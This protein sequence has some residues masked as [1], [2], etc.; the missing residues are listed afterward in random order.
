MF[1][2]RGDHKSGEGDQRPEPE[3][4]PERVNWDA[5]TLMIGVSLDVTK[6]GVF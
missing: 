5:C 1:G 6:E 2:K 3:P 4:K